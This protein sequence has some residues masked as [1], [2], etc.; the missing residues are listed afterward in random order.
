MNHKPTT[1]DHNPETNFS[2]L[3]WQFFDWVAVVPWPK[4][5]VLCFLA[6]IVAGILHLPLLAPLVNCALL[7]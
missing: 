7:L 6:F 5:V 4:M 2:K 3:W 1:P